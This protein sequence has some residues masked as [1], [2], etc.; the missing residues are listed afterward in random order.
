MKQRLAAGKMNPFKANKRLGKA[1]WGFFVCFVLFFTSSADFF[2][3]L[4][5]PDP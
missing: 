3:L 5:L 2:L 4:K 1:L